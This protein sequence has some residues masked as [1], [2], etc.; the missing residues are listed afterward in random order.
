M[1]DATL[2]RI[3]TYT[4]PNGSKIEVAVEPVL[5]WVTALPFEHRVYSDRV[6][7]ITL[8]ETK[9]VTTVSRV[10]LKKDA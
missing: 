7:S 5:V 2:V 8:L 6:R 10:E 4:L 1:K 9:V 3:D